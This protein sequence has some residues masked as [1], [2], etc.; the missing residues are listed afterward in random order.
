MAAMAPA[1][2]DDTRLAQ[3]AV[4]PASFV[5]TQLAPEAAW[6]ASAVDMWL[7]LAA[8]CRGTETGTATAPWILPLGR[9]ASK[10]PKSTASSDPLPGP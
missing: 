9:C 1:S 7:K 4:W 8:V 10:L 5:D 3:E 2:A 6:P